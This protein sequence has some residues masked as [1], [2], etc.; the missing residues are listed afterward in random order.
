[1]QITLPFSATLNIDRKILCEYGGAI[2]GLLGALLIAL[3]NQYSGYG[4]IFFLISNG[5]LIV[6]AMTSRYYA[7]LILQFGFTITSVMGI[8]HWLL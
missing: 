4:F 5:F 6:F 3:N 8:Y 7:I 1:M 2:T